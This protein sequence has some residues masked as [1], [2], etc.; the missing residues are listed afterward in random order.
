MRGKQK[1][2]FI[3][4][5]WEAQE[6]IWNYNF[7]AELIEDLVLG[8]SR[9][10]LKHLEEKMVKF[11]TQDPKLIKDKKKNYAAEMKLKDEIKLEQEGIKEHKA[12]KHNSL[13][14]AKAQRGRLMFVLRYIKN[15]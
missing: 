7:N 10:R 2:F 5:A 14:A 6:K 15:H 1:K 13:S 8:F 12:R 9:E 11:E 3:K 4:K